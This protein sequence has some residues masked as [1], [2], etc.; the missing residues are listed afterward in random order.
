MCED[1]AM[2]QPAKFAVFCPGDLVVVAVDYGE[3]G[4]PRNVHAD[5][6]LCDHTGGV[7]IGDAPAGG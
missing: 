7:R 3:P 1:P 2:D 6:S 4:H 5:G